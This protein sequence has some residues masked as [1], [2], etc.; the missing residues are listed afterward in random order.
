METN[1]LPNVFANHYVF[2]REF[3]LSTPQGIPYVAVTPPQGSTNVAA[4]DNVSQFCPPVEPYT[5]DAA[6][7]AHC[8]S[9]S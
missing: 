4:S 9:R 8:S 2:E 6:N 5:N 3:N 7:T 1:I